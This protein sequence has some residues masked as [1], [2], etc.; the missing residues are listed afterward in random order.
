LFADA[1]SMGVSNYLGKRSRSSYTET[2]RELERLGIEHLPE[3]EKEE[4]RHI[5]QERGLEGDKLEAVVDAITSNKS[6][7]L[8]V[9][10]TM[11][12]GLP[13]D[14]SSPARHGFAT[15]WAFTIAGAIPLT[16][17]LTR[18]PGSLFE[19][20]AIAAAMALFATGALRVFVTGVNW[21][22]GGLEML[23]V[24]SAAAVVAYA[25]GRI[26]AALT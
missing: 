18:L 26:I 13:E 2:Q 1:V 8:D 3:Q 4:V 10:M 15:F 6:A 25:A 14:V 19:I 22:R 23:A 17:Y 11:E 5:F 20:S 12:L 9:M 7:W 21:F 24:G 16:P